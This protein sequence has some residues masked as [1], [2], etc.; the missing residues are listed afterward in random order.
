MVFS[1]C[2]EQH[3][4]L[5]QRLDAYRGLLLQTGLATVFSSCREGISQ[6]STHHVTWMWLLYRGYCPMEDAISRKGLFYCITS[7]LAVLG[8]HRFE[9]MSEFSVQWQGLFSVCEKIGWVC[10]K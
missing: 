8:F 5:Q 6:P 1:G 7:R 4:R 3:Y 9:G 10:S 2:S